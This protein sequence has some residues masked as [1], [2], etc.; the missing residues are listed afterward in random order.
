M[1]THHQITLLAIILVFAI[2]VLAAIRF[3]LN[4]AITQNKFAALDDVDV[5]TESSSDTPSDDS[6]PE[7]IVPPDAPTEETPT[8]VPAENPPAPEPQ[9]PPAQEDAPDAPPEE[10]VTPE[11]PPEETPAEPA[12]E[13]TPE[14]EPEPVAV[15]VAEHPDAPTILPAFADTRSLIEGVVSEIDWLYTLRTSADYDGI[16]ATR[17]ELKT[18]LLSLADTL[19]QPNGGDTD[20][21]QHLLCQSS[22]KLQL[23]NAE[24]GAGTDNAQ[25]QLDEDNSKVLND[26]GGVVNS[27]T[28]A[29]QGQTGL[30]VS[31]F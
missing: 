16:A 9:T 26:I 8:D 28:S 12:P 10:P 25:P 23:L 31:C 13:V 30:S 3:G 11:V 5:T 18:A 4:S 14:P 29:W 21:A 6:T 15:P 24:F 7:A 17:E 1:K 19:E 2:S 22:N 20:T 27:V